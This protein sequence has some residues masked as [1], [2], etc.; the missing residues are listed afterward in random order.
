MY[1]QND[2]VEAVPLDRFQVSKPGYLGNIKR[3]LKEKYIMLLAESADPPEFIVIAS[4]VV[5]PQSDN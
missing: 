4:T 1:L 3:G 5:V 2:L